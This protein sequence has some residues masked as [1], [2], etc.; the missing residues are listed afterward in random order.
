VR[1]R[2]QVNYDSKDTPASS[3]A[4]SIGGVPVANVPNAGLAPG[5]TGLYQFNIVVPANPGNGAYH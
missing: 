5:F 1:P 4:M 2:T 3:F